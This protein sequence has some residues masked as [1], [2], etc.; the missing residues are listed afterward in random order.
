IYQL[1]YGRHASHFTGM[2][3]LRKL[4]KN[5][6]GGAAYIPMAEL[7]GYFA[8]TFNMLDDFVKNADILLKHGFVEANNRLD[9]YSDSVDSIKITSYGLYMFNELA[10]HFAYLDLVCTDTGVF[11][12]QV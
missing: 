10:Y 9:A 6:D 12:E 11:S 8:E 5:V 4:A 1:R 7:K 2:R 3:I